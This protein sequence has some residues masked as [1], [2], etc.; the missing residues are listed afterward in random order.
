MD[1]GPHQRQEQPPSRV[2]TQSYGNA[3]PQQAYPAM[4]QAEDIFQSLQLTITVLVEEGE[5]LLEFSNLFFGKL[6]S[7][8]VIIQNQK[9]IIMM[10]VGDKCTID[11]NAI[12][13]K[14]LSSLDTTA[15]TAAYGHVLLVQTTNSNRLT[16]KFQI[17]LSVLRKFRPSYQ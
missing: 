16:A 3:S 14:F 11:S 1:S 4:T 13:A 15:V 10:F 17:V 9:T 7:H 8:G 2:S 5:G 12:V 6:I